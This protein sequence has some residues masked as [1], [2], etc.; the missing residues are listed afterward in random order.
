MFEHLAV[1]VAWWRR[2]ITIQQK[3]STAANQKRVTKSLSS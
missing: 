2:V 3:K 1:R